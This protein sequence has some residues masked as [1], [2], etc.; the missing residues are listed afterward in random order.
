LV[1][2]GEV[3]KL[4]RCKKDKMKIQVELFHEKLEK[5]IDKA[6]ERFSPEEIAITIRTI[7]AT[8]YTLAYLHELKEKLYKH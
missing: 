8:P 6:E 7:E 5:I 1:R 3:K 4:N 2:F